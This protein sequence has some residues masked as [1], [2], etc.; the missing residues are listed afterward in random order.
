MKKLIIRYTNALTFVNVVELKEHLVVVDS[1]KD[2]HTNEKP[3]E[4]DVCNKRNI[5]QIHVY[6]IPYRRKSFLLS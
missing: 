4:C 6:A 5:H 1:N 3:Y 2:T